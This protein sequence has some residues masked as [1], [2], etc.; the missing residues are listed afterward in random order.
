MFLWLIHIPYN[1]LFADD[2]FADPESL[3][4]HLACG[5]FFLTTNYV[6]YDGPVYLRGGCIVLC[7][8]PAVIHILH[9][10]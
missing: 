1:T 6:T 8:K 7:R 3:K 10:A 4:H 9:E 2:S 5:L